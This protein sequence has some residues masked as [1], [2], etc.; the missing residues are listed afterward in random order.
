MT[1]LF[2]K[3]KSGYWK[4]H[5]QK[6]LWLIPIFLMLVSCQEKADLLVHNAVIYT[7]DSNHT[8]AS[9]FIVDKGKFIAVGGEELRDRYQ[10]TNVVDAKKLP[11]FPG[12]I[13]AHCH[14]MGLGLN[15]SR[16]NLVGTKSLEEIT[17]KLIQYANERGDESTSEFILGRGWDQ[18]DWED[19]SFPTKKL[20]DIIFPDTPVVLE[21]IDGHA[22]LVNQKVLDLAGIK[23]NTKVEGGTI[24]KEK[25]TLT[26]VLVDA[27]MGLV[28][29][30]ISKPSEKQLTEALQTAEKI[31]FRNGLTTVDDAGLSKEHI[32]LINKL[33][34]KGALKMRIY[35]MVQN[36]KASLDHFLNT[37]P[38]KTE[39]LNVRSVKVYADGALGSRGA[40]LKE[41][42]SDKPGHYG[43]FI[44]P[45][46]S[47][48]SLAEKISRSPFQMNTH[49][50]GDDANSKILSI[51][52]N[53]LETSEDPRWRIEHAQVIDPQDFDS[54]DG[55]IIP[56]VQPTHATSDMYW[57]EDRLG[58]KRMEGAYAF[59]K[60][61]KQSNVIALGT[62]FPVEQVSPFLTFYAAVARKDVS[63]YPQEGF[64]MNNALNRTQALLGM[65]RWAA[66]ANFEE[67][68]KGS[69]EV[70]KFADFIILN[71][72]LMKVPL[73]EI[74]S[75]QV[76]ATFL[77]GEIVFS[78]RF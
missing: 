8:I 35:A 77:N 28:D 3:T 25:G 37:G 7:A 21:R 75:T 73:Q 63:G 46:D 5:F 67:H 10:F 53:V 31:C 50:I 1:F 33:Q 71:R 14:F 27:P 40:A 9:A 51:Y 60:L 23:E 76:V 16:V 45:V 29:A 17:D 36:S 34:N 49:A 78:N 2:Y 55:K 32:A 65:T 66:Y 69:I 58:S 18:N 61:L 41:P 26:G 39:R 48:E 6:A 44:T 64:L 38:L 22:Y 59:Q 70:G 11:V 20:L 47:L 68:E 57:A 12:F 30:I 43:T 54:F 74:P 13:D 56:S 4:K 15:E 62:D 72:D 24:I 52:K 19:K 42:Y